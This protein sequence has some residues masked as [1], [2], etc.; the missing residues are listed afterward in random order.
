MRVAT[1]ATV[2]G[3]RQAVVLRSGDLA[4]AVRASFAI[5][6]LFAPSLIGDD[7]L[8]DGGVADNIPVAAARAMGAER[9]IISTLPNTG[10]GG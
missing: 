1:T 9:L 2:I 4:Q 6:L 7:V 10:V 5:P 3:T 8:V